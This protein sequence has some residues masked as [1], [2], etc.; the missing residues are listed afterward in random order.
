MKRSAKKVLEAQKTMKRVHDNAR[1]YLDIMKALIAEEEAIAQD[2]QLLA[3]MGEPSLQVVRTMEAER[4]KMAAAFDKYVDNPILEYLSQFKDLKDRMDELEIRR[5]DMDRYFRDYNAIMAKSHPDPAR[6]S[7]RD[8]IETK[9]NVTKEGYTALFNEMMEDIPKLLNDR[10]RFFEPIVAVFAKNHAAFYGA[11]ANAF[12]TALPSVSAID[13]ENVHG[14]KAPITSVENSA[15]Y[16]HRGTTVLR[17]INAPPPAHA[18][19][20]SPSSTYPPPSTPY[21]PPPSSYAPPH[22]SFAPPPSAE[23]SY[24]DPPTHTSYPPP[25]SYATP[26]AHTSFAPPPT[27]EPSAPPPDPS[28]P[29]LSPTSPDPTLSSPTPT[30]EPTP[31]SSLPPSSAPAP[32]PVAAPSLHKGIRARANFDF[33]AQDE[34]EISFHKGDILNILNN[35]GDWWEGELNGK[36]GNLPSNYVTVL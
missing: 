19:P 5:V 32:A 13:D 21:S 12:E 27:S 6:V 35:E 3:E 7:H 18:Q 9:Y 10:A 22:A 8:K 31:V 30:P 15:R 23:P 34:D 20:S 36:R 33:N 1:R 14:H 17:E 25:T 4:D 24:F 29:A 28:A 2:I 11:T 16:R 26:P